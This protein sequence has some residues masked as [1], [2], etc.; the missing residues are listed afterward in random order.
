MPSLTRRE[1][2]TAG[3]MLGG[4]GFALGCG[5]L[6]QRPKT[7]A[8]AWQ[9][10]G[11]RALHA[12]ADWCW[13]Q[14][15]ADGR[16]CSATYGLLRGG[17]SL[18]PFVLLALHRAATLPGEPTARAV[19]ALLTLQNTEGALGFDGP[20]PD[21]PCYA[22]GMLLSALTR[23]QAPGVRD[24][25]RA[26][27]A[28]LRT[29]QLSG[30]RG[31]TDHPARGGWGMGAKTPHSPPH[32]GHVD[33]SMTRRVIEG[34]RDAGLPANDPCLV[35]AHHF[36]RRCQCE[37]GS[38]FYSPVELA[39]N[40]GKRSVNGAPVGYGS[41]TSDGLLCLLAL[42]Q[43]A[44]EPA[45]RAHRWLRSHHRNDANPGLEGA[46]MQAFATAMRGYYR[47]GASACFA[48]LT[49]PPDWRRELVDAVAS[50]QDADGS[51][52]NANP[53]QKENDPLIATAFALHAL[54]NALDPGAP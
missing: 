51:F 8:P 4:Q 21:Y 35:E 16:F 50:E 45:E 30:T 34:L 41:A 26:G 15:S 1:V 32:A 48:R 18:T 10:E 17:A 12:A 44:T 29:Q 40:K 37:D 20:A 25:T 14:Q 28:W 43:S 24:A 53:V 31:W 36:L 27:V 52:R 13:A 33:L 6:T 9:R 42:E 46:P 3:L 47:A 49:G 54:A 2:L 5:S 38:F 39:L 23:T 11:L 19:Q 22:T 7:D